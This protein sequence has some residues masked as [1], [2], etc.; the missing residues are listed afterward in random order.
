MIKKIKVSELN[1]IADIHGSYAFGIDS[2]NKNVK[3]PLS[4][5]PTLEQQASDLS[6]VKADKVS[7]ATAGNFSALDASGNLVDS[8]TKPSDFEEVDETIL[9]QTDV[10][11]S[12]TSYSTTLPLSA[13]QGAVIADI[14]NGM[15][16]QNIMYGV[17]WDS[18]VSL[19]TGTRIGNTTLHA[20]LPIQSR[21]RR[22]I[23]NV[24]GDVA[25]YLSPSDSAKTDTGYDA[26]LS[27]AE[28]D[29]MVEIPLHYRKFEYEGTKFRCLLS[30]YQLPG[31]A[32]VPKCYIS[33]YEATV[34]RTVALTPKLVSVVNNTASYRG[35]NNTSG[36]DVTYR[37]LLGKPATNISLTNFRVYARNKGE[38]GRNNA[39][40]NCNIPDPYFTM[41]WLYYVEYANLD[42]QAP[43]NATPTAQGYKQGGLGAGVSNL[44][45]TKWSN[46][47][48][49][50]PFIPCGIT[51]SL[52][53]ASG[54]VDFTMPF[55][56]D[57][58]PDNYK[59]IWS[60]ETTYNAD[61]YVS[62]GE[63][64]YKCI[65]ESTGNDVT[66]TTYFTL[67]V[68]TTTSVPTYRGV[69]NPYGHIWKW[70]DGIKCKIQSVA[71]GGKSE[72]Y[73]CNDPSKY[74]STDYTDYEKRGE[75]PRTNGYI[76]TILGGEFGDI[77]PLAIGGDSDKYFSDYF[78]TSIPETGTGQRGVLF[79]GAAHYGSYCGLACS[80][81]IYP[82]S[83]AYANF[84][85]RLCFLP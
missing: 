63:N 33:A 13:N 75:I 14:L 49:Y 2:D 19:P 38:A 39:G 68:R 1:P 3:I 12:L 27:G 36:W 24:S 61:E 41:C 65:L 32:E 10:V 31:Y 55:E 57:A 76:K 53:N 77:M 4:G 51:N 35:G 74:Q 18:S 81:T 45:P 17:E 26:D 11:D 54:T 29:A 67:Q 8:L 84:G 9:R 78:Y 47:N 7:G 15:G 59:G 85:S 58:G 72:Y 80:Y 48:G 46:Y 16:V 30:E 71:D 21:M 34:D 42:I 73:V 60:A 56:Y 50:N 23:L 66:N 70:T 22:C 6:Q 43:Y 20:T 69:E 52:G 83:T 5:I 37:T 40:W 44:N 62:S 64:L 82:L 25:R 79:G 28:G